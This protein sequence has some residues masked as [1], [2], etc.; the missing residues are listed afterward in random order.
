M[1]VKV[2]RSDFRIFEGLYNAV[3]YLG[4]GSIIEHCK[5]FITV[6]FGREGMNP[7]TIREAGYVRGNVSYN[8]IMSLLES[9]ELESELKF[10][11]RYL[12]ADCRCTTDTILRKTGNALC[13]PVGHTYRT[14]I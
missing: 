12:L 9:D 8:R 14:L 5:N 3:V 10:Q 6:D 7:Y 2:Y 13:Y 1:T 4:A 11:I